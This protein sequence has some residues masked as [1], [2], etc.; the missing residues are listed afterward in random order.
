[1]KCEGIIH[2]GLARELARLR[3]TDTFV[4][5][6]AGLPVPADV[7]CIDLGYRY[8]QPSFA[9]V[10]S[11]VLHEVVIEHS[12]VSTD[13]EQANPEVLAHILSLGLQPERIDHRSFKQRVHNVSF[14][15]R[16]G[17]ATKFAN[18]LCRAGVAFG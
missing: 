4:I 14:V 1:M 8:G 13:I 7:P 18:L 11:A 9:D 2:A 12:W 17:E 10:S 3:H 16:T 5:S 15:I 6:D